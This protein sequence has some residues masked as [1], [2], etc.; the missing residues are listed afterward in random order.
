MGPLTP[1]GAELVVA[2][3]CFALVFLIVG[4]VLIPRITRTLDERHEKLEGGFDRAEGLQEEVA[5]LARQIGQENAEGRR[6]AARVRQE[7]IEEGAESIAESRAEGQRVRDE[8]V[9]SGHN[10][11]AEERAL[12]EAA[13]HAELGMIATELAG[14]IVGEPLGDFVASGDTVERFLAETEN[15]KAANSAS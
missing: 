14:K 8:L 6:E 3:I 1:D 15:R 5:E 10:A 12:A 4:K 2:V 11:I 13:L 9:V 7:L